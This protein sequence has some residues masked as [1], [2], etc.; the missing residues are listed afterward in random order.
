MG[1]PENSFWMASVFSKREQRRSSVERDVLGFYAVSYPIFP[2][3]SG[4]MLNVPSADVSQGIIL[5][6]K[7]A[8]EKNCNLLK[9]V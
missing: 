2:T 5:G 9:T 8:A 7:L 3:V 6:F 1:V 4:L